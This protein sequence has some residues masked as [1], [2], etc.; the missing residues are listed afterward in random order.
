MKNEKRLVIVLVVLIVMFLTLLSA[1]G[2]FEHIKPGQETE[3]ESSLEEEDLIVVGFS[4]LGSESVC[5]YSWLQ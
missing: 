2:G 3:D 5:D 4:Q 1:R